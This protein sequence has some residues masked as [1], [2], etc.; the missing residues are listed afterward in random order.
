MG[1]G[2]TPKASMSMS[3][4]TKEGSV[5]PLLFNQTGI[6][7]GR[8]QEVKHLSW[9]CTHVINAVRGC[10]VLDTRYC[11]FPWHRWSE[12]VR[13]RFKNASGGGMGT[14]FST[15]SDGSVLVVLA[16]AASCCKYGCCG[17]TS[18]LR[19]S[20]GSVLFPLRAW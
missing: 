7:R 16:V 15:L 17:T 3:I 10:V 6:M 18:R 11:G 8:I 9:M 4:D 12:V 1:I 13:N 14:P 19:G 5:S 20:P 2:M